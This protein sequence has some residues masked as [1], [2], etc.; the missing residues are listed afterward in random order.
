[1]SDSRKSSKG[2]KPFELLRGKCLFYY[3]ILSR[4]HKILSK[5]H[6]DLS[7]SLKSLSI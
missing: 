2:F 1:M 5:P 7:Q 6:K 4:I 3:K